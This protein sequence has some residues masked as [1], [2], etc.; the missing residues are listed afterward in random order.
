M[1]THGRLAQLVEHSIYTRAV[2]GSSPA[3]PTKDTTALMLKRLILRFGKPFLGIGLLVARIWWFVFRPTRFGV[4]AAVLN[5]D[6]ILLVRHTYGRKNWTF[7]GGGISKGEEAE[8]AL[9]RELKEEL[10]ISSVQLLKYAGS[11]VSQT[12]YKKDNVSMYVVRLNDVRFEI[13]P[14]EIEEAKW[15]KISEMPRLT[16]NAQKMYDIA[17]PYFN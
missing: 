9:I 2:A 1:F 11:F 15:F 5:N 6:N 8:K 4:K 7:P 3:S 10:S 12:E 16:F 14:F 17:A 13:D